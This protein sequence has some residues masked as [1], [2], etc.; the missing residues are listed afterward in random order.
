MIARFQ[1]PCSSQISQYYLDLAYQG[2][3]VRYR[4]ANAD[5]YYLARWPQIFV[6]S[7]KFPNYPFY[8]VPANRFA[9]SSGDDDRKPGFAVG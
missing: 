3:L 7:E 5:N 1:E 4:F 2:G 9:G 6:V 8:P